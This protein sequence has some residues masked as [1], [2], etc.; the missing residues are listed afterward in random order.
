MGVFDDYGDLL[1]RVGGVLSNPFVRPLLGPASEAGEA[2]SA[3]GSLLD[4]VQDHGVEGLWNAASALA[5]GI[6]VAEF[7]LD[8]ATKAGTTVLAGGLKTVAGL[9]AMTGGTSDPEMAAAYS[10]SAQR[11]NSV[12]DRLSTAVPDDTWRGTGADAYEEANAQQVKRARTMPDIDLDVVT[13]V[14]MEANRLV[15]TRRVLNEAATVMG[16]S[17]PAAIALRAVPRIGKLLSAELEITVT[18]T[19]VGASLVHMNKLSEASADA[20][21]SIE[22]ATRLYQELANSC[23]PVWM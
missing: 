19:S 4:T 14:G 9:Q 7:F 2:M 23:H 18:T 8:K 16:N 11:F 3:M 20:T 15:T 10:E 5:D 12:A 1:E 17:I 22:E 21:K 6:S 13:A